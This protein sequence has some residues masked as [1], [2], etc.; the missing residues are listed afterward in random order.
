MTLESGA[1]QFVT[2][3]QELAFSHGYLAIELIRFQDRLQVDVDVPPECMDAKVPSFLLQ[4]LVENAIKHGV[5][6]LARPSRIQ[7]RARK[8]GDTLV[9]EVEDDGRGFE[10]GRRGIGTGT[11][12]ERLEL[13]YKDLQSFSLVSESGKGT[14]ARIRLP[15]Q[16]GA[17][18]EAAAGEEKP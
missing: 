4:P 8:D 15:W 3:R 17:E 2:L 12:V 7:V 14:L 16:V 5:A 1:E 11:T 10:Q 13:L 18:L 9:L 6:D